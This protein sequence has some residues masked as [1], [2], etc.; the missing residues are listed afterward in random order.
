MCSRANSQRR[1]LTAGVALRR[2]GQLSAG[3]L[4]RDNLR[5]PNAQ[6]A[7]RRRPWQDARRTSGGAFGLTQVGAVGRAFEIQ[8]HRAR[9]PCPCRSRGMRADRQGGARG[10]RRPAPPERVRHEGCR[11]VALHFPDAR[12]VDH[13]PARSRSGV[14]DGRGAV[15]LHARLA[16]RLETVELEAR[17]LLET[18][19]LLFAVPSSAGRATALRTNVATRSS[20]LRVNILAL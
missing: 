16:F 8:D 20:R 3:I 7:S 12:P 14:G 5:L 11:H 1:G 18:D 17:H 15:S 13:R 6:R 9:A 10:C 4:V 19:R 2:S